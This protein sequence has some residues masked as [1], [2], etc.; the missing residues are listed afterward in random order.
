MTWLP[1]CAACPAVDKLS[2]ADPNILW[3]LPFVAQPPMADRV[4]ASKLDLMQFIF[5]FM[6]IPFE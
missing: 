3:S 6:T 1:L 5:F 4:S 2:F